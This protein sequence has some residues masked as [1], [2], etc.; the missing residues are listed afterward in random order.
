M[1]FLLNQLVDR[2]LYV[3]MPYVVV[4]RRVDRK[5]VTKRVP[6]I[7]RWAE[8]SKII[9]ADSPQS[10]KH[11]EKLFGA[12]SNIKVG[13]IF[14]EVALCKRDGIPEYHI[15][16]KLPLQAR[17]KYIAFST[18]DTMKETIE[19]HEKIMRENTEAQLSKHRGK[20][21]KRRR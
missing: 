19:R 9:Y 20:A 10:K 13:D 6:L 17:A 5:F 8:A 7:E 18:L 3:M 14:S 12:D 15:F 11:R 1:G 2:W 16:K 4:Q 21:K